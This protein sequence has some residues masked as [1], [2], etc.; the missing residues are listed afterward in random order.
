MAA[1]ILKL[2]ERD[3]TEK[4]CEICE[5]I[6]TDGCSDKRTS[7][8]F[9]REELEKFKKP[10][11]DDFD[12]KKNE[13]DVTDPED[14][15]NEEL[16]DPDDIPRFWRRYLVN[17]KATGSEDVIPGDGEDRK[18]TKDLDTPNGETDETDP[19]DDLD[20][21]DP[22]E[23]SDENL[24]PEERKKAEKERKK[25]EKEE[26]K[27][28]KQEEKD[29]KSAED[30]KK[31]EEEAAR[32]KQN[33]LYQK[34][35]SGIELCPYDEREK[36]NKYLALYC[37]IVRHAADFD[38]SKIDVPHLTPKETHRIYE[39]VCQDYPEFFWMRTYQY[40]YRGEDVFAMQLSFRFTDE[41]GNLNAR[42]IR[43]K[44]K[45]IRSAAK[46]YTAG[47]TRA[48]DRYEAALTIYRRLILN[49][50]YDGV[51]LNARVD[52]DDTR[53]D[54]LR[55][56]HAALVG[57]KVVCAGYAVAMQYLL[58]TVGIPCATVVSERDTKGISHA[59][60]L[61]KIGKKCYYIDS[62]WGDASNTQTGDENANT[63]KY[64]YFCVP[65]RELKLARTRDYILNHTPRLEYYPFLE[66][67]NFTDL[68]YHRAHGYYI[69]H[70]DEKAIK[71]VI[72]KTVRRY[73]RKEM[74]DFAIH[75]R[76]PVSELKDVEMRLLRTNGIS[77]ILESLRTSL[78]KKYA[79]L[80]EGKAFLLSNEATGTIRI[81][82]Q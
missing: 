63:V 48:T 64:D 7:F 81:F 53:E 10:I 76:C 43:E 46:Y 28:K 42:E 34:I 73:D 65:L 51:G 50:D 26:A 71:D 69:Q 33:P 44:R 21:T 62:T 70:Y 45:A 74:G 82:F 77:T 60:N 18:G 56:L 61:M 40:T 32:K 23:P 54:T 35:K 67:M 15:E 41:K 68:E 9:L 14:T 30:G 80:L 4:L 25:A 72:E 22:T 6:L 11:D 16:Y 19:A 5:Y 38:T 39:L 49:F 13:D 55:S 24:T 57:K 31:K 3:M 12:G 66:E 2:L 1:G 78:P 75:L 37:A 59:F 36:T 79:K 17:E 47:I 20:P 8:T 52:R 58:Q 27:R 29:K